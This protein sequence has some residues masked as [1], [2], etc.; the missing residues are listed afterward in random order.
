MTPIFRP[1]ADRHLAVRIRRLAAATLLALAVFTAASPVLGFTSK[2]TCGKPT[3]SGR[4]TVSLVVMK[5]DGTFE[6]PEVSLDV[7]SS[8]TA[9]DKAS[10]LRTEFWARVAL[11]DTV[12]ALGTTAEVSFKGQNGWMIHSVNVIRDDSQEPDQVALGLPFPDQEAVCSLGG[13]ASGRDMQGNP[14]FV[15]LT[16]GQI[17]VTQPTQ[18]GMPAQVI[19]QMLIG[20]LNQA[21]IG[22]RFA[23]GEDFSGCYQ[24]LPHDSSVIWFQ[25]PDT[26]G[27]REEITDLG[28]SLDIAAALNGSPEPPAAVSADARPS[29]LRLDVAPSLFSGEGVSVR[30][31]G[32]EDSR[33]VRGRIDVFDVMGRKVR[34]LHEGGLPAPGVVHWDGR[35]EWRTLTPGGVYFVRLS[36]P[37]G[38][39]VRRVVHVRE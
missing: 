4:L 19:E 30:Y 13:T 15:R 5:D 34:T 7:D 18:P 27:F 20:Q 8:W 3:R 17:T 10:F 16:V 11:R 32:G 21:G 28:L 12:K 22:A 9:A 24:H 38:N 33:D 14:A 1:A 23:T 25:A 39:L 29:G 35:N 6:Y 26:T 37:Q 2:L 31:S 36:S